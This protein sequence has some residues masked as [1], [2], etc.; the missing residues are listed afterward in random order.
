[1][2]KMPQDSKSC[3][4]Y[5]DLQDFV[6]DLVFMYMLSLFRVRIIRGE[7]KMTYVYMYLLKLSRQ[8]MEDFV[9][10]GRRLLAVSD[11]S[12]TTEEEVTEK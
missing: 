9:V 2:T 8:P 4:M 6:S 1:M 12:F 10:V 3:Q 7:R 11:N 5:V